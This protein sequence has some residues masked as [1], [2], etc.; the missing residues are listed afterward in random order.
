MNGGEEAVK[1][2]RAWSQKERWPRR[3]GNQ[4]PKVENLKKAP[5]VHDDK[6]HSSAKQEKGSNQAVCSYGRSSEFRATDNSY[7]Y[8]SSPAKPGELNVRDRVYYSALGTQGLAQACNIGG[9]A[10]CC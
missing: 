3:K 9:L 5:V 2:T 1:E 7:S 10:H 4:K 6:C 8:L